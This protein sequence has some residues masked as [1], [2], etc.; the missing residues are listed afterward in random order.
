[1]SISIP[2]RLTHRLRVRWAEVDPQGIV[3]NAH[4]LGYVDVAMTEYWRALGLPYAALAERYRGE[5]FARKV[6]LDYLGSARFDDW[7]EVAVRCE[8][9]GTSSLTMAFRI[10]RQDRTLVEGEL[11]YVFADASERQPQ[12]LPDELRELVNAFE[13]GKPMF[14]VRLG[15]WRTFGPDART[16]RTEV[17]IGE[18]QIPPD[19]EW[20]DADE[21]SV[22]AV[23]YNRLAMPVA[24]GRLL[25]HVP[26]VAKIGR[27]AVVR[28]ARGCGVGR[29]VLD[30]LIQQA[31][32][33]GD[34]A[35]LLHAQVSASGFYAQAG[36]VARGAEF[37]DVGIPHVEMVRTL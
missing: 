5:L 8:R 35:A 36:F 14:D 12:V 7:V 33:R 10:A 25:E 29:R 1:M 13:A 16:V 21:S 17:F 18:Q 6:T 15:D 9:L 4:Y 31:R 24:T 11:V 37:D 30:A 22:H 2:F 26:G 32:E 34:R 27:M 19:M 3:F 20:D 28:A 23:A